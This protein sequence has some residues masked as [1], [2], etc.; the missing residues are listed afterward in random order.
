MNVFS[1]E[2]FMD[3]LAL[4]AGADPVAFRLKHL[5]D[6][7]AKDVVQLAAEKFGWRA[8]VAAPAGRGY[9]FAFARYENLGA[10]LAMAVEIEIDRNTGRVRL[11]RAVAADDS[12]T[13]VNPNA[14]ENQ[15][16]G[17]ILQ[18]ASWT[19][20]EQ[21]RF[22][23]TGITSVDWRTYPIM[24]FAEVPD[25]VDVHVIDRPGQ[26]FL[27]TGEASQGPTSAAIA[28]A[29]ANATGMRL[30]EPPFTPETV[31]KAIGV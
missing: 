25:S 15:I 29:I 18:S 3:E 26:P 24:R 28:N 10:Y 6:P 12:G 5:D 11:V 9:G 1:I 30:R 16:Q 20:N 19:L 31:K 4:V 2:S 13:A 22:N 14:I 17:G 8:G 21:V 27:G 23:R 7:R